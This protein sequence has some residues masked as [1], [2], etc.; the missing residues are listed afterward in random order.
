MNT[1]N[2]IYQNENLIQSEQNI[3]QN[4]NVN[5]FFVEKNHQSS[6]EYNKFVIKFTNNFLV[7]PLS[8]LILLGFIIPAMVIP[9]L[10]LFIKIAIISS[11]VIFSLM[12]MIFC[13]NKIILEKD[14]SNRKV[15]IKVINFL[16]FPKMKLNFDIENTHLYVLIEISQG[17]YSI[18]E[19]FTL[20]IINDYKNLADIDLDASNIKQKPAIIL[21][22]FQ[23]VSTGK[24]NYTGFTQALNNFIG[25]SITHENP[26]FFNNNKYLSKIDLSNY[27]KFSDH[28]STFHLKNPL[29]TSCFGIC[30]KIIAI[31]I[32][33][34]TISAAVA[35]LIS[36]GAKTHIKIIGVIFFPIGNII[37]YII[38]I[39][40]NCFD[41]IFR[42]DC[43]YSKNFDR[44]FIG[45]VK[46]NKTKYINTF[47]YQ[48]NNISR[49]ILER[50]GNSSVTN[51]DLKVIFKNNETQRICT[52][53]NKTQVE[54]E[55]LAFLLN[56]R[57]N[58]FS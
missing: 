38:Y 21:Y 6:I 13:V 44:I 15:L 27:M 46:Y 12:L 45:L 28:F 18:N 51:Y 36:K 19:Y 4:I 22:S 14:I 5:Q 16:C 53:K 23:N 58:I 57:L 56:E 52:I 47:E 34:I 49:F 35:L 29:K 31:F 26:L 50:V 11:G 41:N 1:P 10:D 30:F 7:Y 42:I 55:K 8:I 17:E 24:Y 20:L 3:Q 54:L 43:I 37:L 2:F 40:Y 9:K 48:I 32:N 25:S 39:L 33:L